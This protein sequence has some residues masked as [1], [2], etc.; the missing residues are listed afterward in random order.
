MADV[1]YEWK[2]GG[3]GAIGI[4]ENFTLPGYKVVQV[5]AREKTEELTTTGTKYSRLVAQIFLVRSVGHLLVRF[6]LPTLL[7]VFASFFPLTLLRLEPSTRAKI[8]AI[9]FLTGL[10]YTGSYYLQPNSVNYVL[11]SLDCFLYTSLLTM[12]IALA[13]TSSVAYLSTESSDEM[14]QGLQEDHG[15]K[16]EVVFL[17]EK[18][19][20]IALPALYMVYVFIH[21]VTNAT[22]VAIGAA[23][24]Y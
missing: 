11:T 1:R 22:A 23:D 9:I 18:W 2:A 14:K 10:L 16:P 13:I 12:L 24:D 20:R 7:F 6:Y 8:S 4:G 19:P 15:H 3:S 21:C 17:L 5:R